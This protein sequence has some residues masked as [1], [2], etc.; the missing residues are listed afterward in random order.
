M[1]GI[2]AEHLQLRPGPAVR[3]QH[4]STVVVPLVLTVGGCS[5]QL[6]LIAPPLHISVPRASL[7]APVTGGQEEIGRLVFLRHCYL[8]K[9]E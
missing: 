3:A 5:S 2:L 4:Y 8:T 7:W 9:L 1:K 6:F